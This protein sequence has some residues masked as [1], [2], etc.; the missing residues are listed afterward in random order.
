VNLRRRLAAIERR[1]PAGCPACGHLPGAL[2]T[3]VLRTD[4][5]APAGPERC[6]TCGVV[7][8]FTITIGSNDETRRGEGD[9][10][11]DFMLGG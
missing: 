9:Q 5:S 7:L 6:P 11:F 2:V 10:R 4:D 8:W 3:F 1:R